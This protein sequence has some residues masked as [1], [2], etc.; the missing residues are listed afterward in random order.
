[1]RFRK[2]AFTTEISIY[3]RRK[4][5]TKTNADINR[6]S[7]WS[8]SIPIR[9]DLRTSGSAYFRMENTISGDSCKVSDGL[10]RV[11]KP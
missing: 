5:Q 1:M 2:D 9:D 6:R 8:E 3:T 11:E 4:K 7:F 10:L